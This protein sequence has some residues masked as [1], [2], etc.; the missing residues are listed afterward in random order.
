MESV[1]I[2]PNDIVYGGLWGFETLL[3]NKALEDLLNLIRSSGALEDLMYED[4]RV[5][6]WPGWGCF[7]ED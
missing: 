5:G 1:E 4:R 3:G 2:R 6:C 7:S